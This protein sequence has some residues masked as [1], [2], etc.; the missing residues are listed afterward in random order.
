MTAH[1][2]ATYR[3]QRS[4]MTRRAVV[5]Y[6]V[7]DGPV[8]KRQALINGIREC[9]TELVELGYTREAIAELEQVANDAEVGDL[10]A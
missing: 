10:D 2:G 5:S 6:A 1:S 8:E 3:R 9:A 4:P 7:D